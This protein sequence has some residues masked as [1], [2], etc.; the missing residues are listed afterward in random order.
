MNGEAPGWGPEDPS[1]WLNFTGEFATL[2]LSPTNQLADPGIAYF[3]PSQGWDCFPDAFYTDW[4]ANVVNAGAYLDDDPTL[5]PDARRFECGSPN[6]AG[7]HALRGSL[8][9]L[10]DIGV[11]RIEARAL[12]LSDYLCEGLESKG[13][14]IFSSRRPKEKSQIVSFHKEGVDLKSVQL[15]LRKQQIVVAYRDGRL[16]ASPHFYTTHADLNRLLN[17][18]P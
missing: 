8:K 7:L 3:G 12:A 13:Y 2:S 15:E 18:L 6:N 10:L 5:R 11:S 14:A 4:T 17:A 16:R 1:G 9:M